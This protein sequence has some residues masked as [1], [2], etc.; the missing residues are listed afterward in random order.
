MQVKKL[1]QLRKEKLTTTR[2]SKTRRHKFENDMSKP[3]TVQ[4]YEDIMDH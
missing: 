3:V 4:K 1:E 2:T